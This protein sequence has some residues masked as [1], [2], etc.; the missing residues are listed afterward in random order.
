MFPAALR[1]VNFTGRA[2]STIRRGVS[3]AMRAWIPPR[4]ALCAAPGR[5]ERGLPSGACEALDLCADCEADFPAGEAAPPAAASVD[6][7]VAAYAYAWPVD[8][9]IRALKFRGQR[10]FARVLGVLVGRERFAAGPPWPDLVVPV[11]LHLS[12]RLERGFDQA[13]DLAR[14]AARLLGVPF[15][16]RLLQRVRAT[17]AQSTLDASARA[18]NVAGAFAVRGPVAGRRVALVDDVLTTGS[19]AA[20]AAAA[21]R[22]AGVRHIEVWA[23]ARATART[24]DP[25]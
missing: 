21:L 20:A 11:P 25:A 12:R 15:A 8:A 1:S 10:E 5:I 23:A 24:R 9:C 14:P 16:P 18:A 19:T 13:V 7:W 3:A 6:L 22:A 4:C 2:R 17:A